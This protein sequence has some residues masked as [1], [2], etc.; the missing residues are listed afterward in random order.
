MHPHFP[1]ASETVERR[2]RV[3]LGREPGDL[4]L[5]GGLVVNVFTERVEPAN[6]I[7]ADGWI[8]GVGPYDWPARQVIPVSGRAILPGL[9]D[10]HVHLESTL[11]TPAELARLIVPHGTT[12]LVSDSHE[13]GNV[14]GIPG[15]ELLLKA[16][17][18]L[19][20]DLFFMASSC[21]PATHWEHAGAVLGP[22]EVRELLARPR[23]LGLAEMMDI[24]AVLN[25]EPDVMAKLRAALSLGRVLDGH[26]PGLLGRDLQAYVAAGMR[27]DH[28]SSTVEEAR[29][30]AALGMLV[31]VREGSVA[32]NLDTILPLLAAGELGDSWCLVTDDVF[33]DNLRN[34]GHVDGLLRRVV[35]GG[36][37]AA[38]AV[39][40]T[41]LVP[42]RHYRLFDRGAVAPGYRADL[43]I[44]DDLHG[45]HPALVLK[46]GRVVARDGAFVGDLQTPPLE[47]GNTVHLAPVDAA[48]FHLPLG[49][50]VCPVIRVIP[51]QIVTHLEMQKVRRVDGHWSF[52]P[53]CD[54]ALIA[55]IERHRATGGIGLGLVSGFGLRRAGALGSSV[56]HDSHN[57]IVAGTNARD[58]LAC[59]RSLQE[60]GGGFV[61]AAEGAV[62]A[63][64]PLPIAGLLSPEC[65][66]TVCRQLG[67]VGEAARALGCGLAAPFGSLSFL[68]LPVIPE[69]RITDQGLFDVRTQQFLRL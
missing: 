38:K 2:I 63:R 8:A 30:K 68:A 69:L 40:H 21:V 35:A 39:R 28:E 5:T 31:Q 32:R 64:L 53:E 42:A 16:S 12:A 22:A 4:V 65:A 67:E 43:A 62:T 18:G 10:S 58:M 27:S 29:L 55:S 52:D 61:V 23:I 6:V 57:L 49:S 51:G 45:F 26:A 37:A 19:P 66:D 54:V 46:N 3:A 7:V 20:L 33:P 15:I 59:V 14:L 36:V 44:V 1:D 48:A 25:G 13:I 47:H 41:T 9:I 60:S 24:P 11:L 50:E 17:V 56:A 34:H